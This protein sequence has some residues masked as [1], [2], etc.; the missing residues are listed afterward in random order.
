MPSPTPYQL[1]GQRMHQDV[2]NRSSRGPGR[3]GANINQGKHRVLIDTG[4][5]GLTARQILNRLLGNPGVRLRRQ[6]RRHALLAPRIVKSPRKRTARDSLLVVLAARHRIRVVVLA[7]VGGP[8][9][10]WLLSGRRWLTTTGS[11]ESSLGTRFCQQRTRPPRL[12]PSPGLAAGQVTQVVSHGRHHHNRLSDVSQPWS[13]GLNA[14]AGSPQN[15]HSG[16]PPA[17][18][19][20]HPVVLAVAAC[21][22]S[23]LGVPF[24]LVLHDRFA[25][26]EARTHVQ[27]IRIEQT[28]G[29]V[30]PIHGGPGPTGPS[31]TQGPWHIR[32]RTGGISSAALHPERCPDRGISAVPV[33]TRPTC[34]LS[35]DQLFLHDQVDLDTVTAEL[36]AVV[37]QIVQPTASCSGCGRRSP[38]PDGQP[39]PTARTGMVALRSAWCSARRSAA[40]RRYCRSGC[41][42]PIAIRC[43]R[44]SRLPRE[45]VGRPDR[46]GWSAAMADVLPCTGL[47]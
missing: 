28:F 9:S 3:F 4:S 21:I 19:S 5:S 24:T 32:P 34:S 16:P 11:Q 41:E 1:I 20:I 17:R 6:R 46:N 40:T 36:L 2:V 8:L 14:R 39:C 15:K 43:S 12:G 47:L 37:R 10:L 25:P 13:S 45:A 7:G 42:H 31:S 23:S 35:P 18:T 38:A 22:P 29:Q 44:R 33:D 27:Q 26:T 30:N